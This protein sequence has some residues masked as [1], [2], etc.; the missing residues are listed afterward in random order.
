MTIL[1][2]LG[3][4]VNVLPGRVPAKTTEHSNGARFFGIAEIS[5]RLPRTVEPGIDLSRATYLRSGDV[6]VALLGDL[7]KSALVDDRSDGAALGRECA[8]LRISD[9]EALLPAWLYAWTQ[10]PHFKAQVAERASG[11]VMR[12]INTRAL[13]D[14][15]LPLPEL[16]YQRELEAE[17]SRY[18]AALIAA[19]DM[20]RTLE[21]LRAAT[22]SLA[23]AQVA[24]V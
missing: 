14:F 22:S 6:V 1:V 16:P 10:S 2:R 5:G 24:E 4:V 17:V 11:T 20:I 12:R 21:D 9:R 3:D 19:K 18:D 15:R 7:G 23:M 8:A 13:P